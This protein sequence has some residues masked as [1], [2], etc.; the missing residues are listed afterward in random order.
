MH[1]GTCL[2]SKWALLKQNTGVNWCEKN[3]IPNG[4][5]QYLCLPAPQITSHSAKYTCV[6]PDG[7]HLAADMKSCTTGTKAMS[8]ADILAGS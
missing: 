8:K 1:S 2:L 3:G 4:G 6:C 7:M 5:C